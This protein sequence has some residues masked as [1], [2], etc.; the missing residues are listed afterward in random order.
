[1]LDNWKWTEKRRRRRRRRNVS[2]FVAPVRHVAAT[3]T[4]TATTTTTTWRKEPPYYWI[5]NRSFSVL[6][7]LLS[8]R[9]LFSSPS[10]NSELVLSRWPITA[11]L[12]SSFACSFAYQFPGIL[13]LKK[14]IPT[15]FFF[16]FPSS[17]SLSP[18]LPPL[19]PQLFGAGLS[20]CSSRSFE[21]NRPCSNLF[22]HYYRC[23]YCYQYGW[24]CG[25]LKLELVRPRCGSGAAPVRLQCGFSRSPMRDN[26]RWGQRACRST[27]KL[28]MN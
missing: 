19:L 15:E 25:G 12:C 9:F 2:S 3:T 5:I 6:L 24:W 18:S 8:I 13:Y 7:F 11:E 10:L 14:K 4:A 27:W 17:L 21:P 16:F 1:M 22:I 28:S 23:H 26:G 20:R